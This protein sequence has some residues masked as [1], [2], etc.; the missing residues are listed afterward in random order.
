MTPEPIACRPRAV[1]RSGRNVLRGSARSDKR[2]PMRLAALGAT[3][4][5]LSLA[6]CAARQSPAPKPAPSPPA[7]SSTQAKHA[8]TETR[9]WPSVHLGPNEPP[10]SG[11]GCSTATLPKWTYDAEKGRASLDLLSRLSV[12][13]PEGWR[14]EQERDDL[15]VISSPTQQDG[16]RPVF[17]LFVGPVCESRNM[18]SVHERIV[19]RG[20]IDLLPPE[21]LRGQLFSPHG[22][23][24]VALGGPVGES[25]MLLDTTVQTR[26]GPRVIDAAST[27]LFD[28]KDAFTAQSAAFC[29]AA[30]N[31][32]GFSPCMKTYFAMLESLV[33]S[34]Q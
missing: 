25:L 17:E 1:Q 27:T 8:Q 20:L 28:A 26:Q 18:P 24:Q 11:S 9:T 13:L 6:A 21:E 22:T 5:V 32:D 14:V 23:G 19:A 10:V 7:S 2:T 30:Q 15:L 4:M 12:V 31:T 3:C 29:P 16:A 33:A 34:L